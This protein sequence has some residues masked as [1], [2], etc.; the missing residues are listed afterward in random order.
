MTIEK[1]NQKVTY[2][3]TTGPSGRSDIN[4]VRQ[5]EGLAVARYLRSM[6]WR[7]MRRRSMRW[8]PIRRTGIFDTNLYEGALADSENFWC[9]SPY[10]KCDFLFINFQ[11][12][13]FFH[14][15]KIHLVGQSTNGP[16]LTHDETGGDPAMETAFG[17]PNNPPRTHIPKPTIL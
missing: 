5:V 12:I 14:L 4:A 1:V 6:R 13:N 8:K 11:F 3:P 15:T 9:Q 17:D 10:S 2:G 7:L 16:A